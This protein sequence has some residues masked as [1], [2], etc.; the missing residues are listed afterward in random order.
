MAAR[1]ATRALCAKIPHRAFISVTGAN[2]A[3]F[4]NGL[5]TTTVPWPAVGGFYSAFLAASGKVLYDVFLW[6]FRADNQKEGYLIEY[7]PRS[8]EAPTLESM[9]KKH[10]LRSRVKI[11][12]VADEWDV[13]AAWGQ[14]L[15]EPERKW[16]FGS[17]GA[18]EPVWKSG[19]STWKGRD[20]S[21]IRDLR[22][23]GM[24]LR[25]LTTKDK[26][27]EETQTHEAGSAED[28][29]I[30]RILRGVPEGSVE[31]PALSALP[32][33]SNMDIMGG[34]DFR[35]GC[36]VGQ[37]LTVRT[38]HTGVVRRRIYPVQIYPKDQ[39]PRP[40]ETI[41]KTIPQLEPTSMTT[42]K[43][44]VPERGTKPKLLTSLH[45][46]GLAVLRSAQLP[47]FERDELRMEVNGPGRTVF[48]VK[49]WMP[50]WWPREV[51]PT[52]VEQ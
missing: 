25:I 17:Q 48:N 10:V 35:K 33:N 50:S 26:N 37:E 29:T 45:G 21:R 15:S 31:L 11:Q 4:L 7:D 5:L 20:A 12:N 32:L 27:P 14:E 1:A 9:L 39:S 51:I 22:A 43:G 18:V 28:Y 16:R 3:Q 42:L 38:Y 36:Y 40:I 24:G 52:D 30:H 46:V 8:S 2:T 23:V 34:I 47:N 13:W 49:P 19:I 41:D 6:P 44:D